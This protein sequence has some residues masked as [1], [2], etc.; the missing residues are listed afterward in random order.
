MTART[1]R[2]ASVLFEVAGHGA[3]QPI[4][5]G[6]SVEIPNSGAGAR[7]CSLVPDHHDA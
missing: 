4:A 5:A 3:A 1:S 7:S 6:R 2:Y